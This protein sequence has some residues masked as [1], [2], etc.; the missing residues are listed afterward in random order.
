MKES[1]EPKYVLISPCRD[2]AKYMPITIESIVQQTIK[3]A[4]WIIVDDGST[5]NT[6]IL[7]A[8]AAH[9]YSF[10]KIISLPNRGKRLL[11]QGVIEA[12]NSGLE[13]INL[14]DYDYL[15]KLDMDLKIPPNY[16]EIII[17][18]ME[19][20]PRI[21][22]CS[23]QPY[24][25]NKKGKLISEKC[26]NDMSVG[27]IKFYRVECFQE[28]G[29]FIP[30]VMWDGIDCHRCRMYGWIACS[31]DESELNFIHLRP[32]GSSHKGIITGRMRHG[33]GQYFMGTGLF[34]IIASSLFRMTRPPLIIGGF[35]IL[36]GYI[37]SF[38]EGQKRYEDLEFRFFLRQYQ[39]NCL[40]K[41]KLL[42]TKELE[43][44][45]AQK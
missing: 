17:Q 12:F 7:L 23:G 40:L 6:P 13:L 1:I 21:G 39:W 25:I 27:M 3:P 43:K 34:Y 11:G 15:C 26:G 18:R 20:N 2:E 30:Q 31:W 10:I 5:D 4:T 24:F 35:A 14:K 37:K 22:T 36:I 19:T 45:Q 9:K 29:G 44:Q 33:A 28:I 32:M 41:G 8:E 16:F 42:A 38:L